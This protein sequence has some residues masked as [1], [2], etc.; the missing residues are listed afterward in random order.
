VRTAAAIL[1]GALACADEPVRL[2]NGLVV[3]LRPLE[4]ATGVTVMV[5]FDVGEDHD[6]VGRSGTAHL[7]EHLYVTAAA[8]SVKSRTVQEWLGAHSLGANA[9]TGGSYTLVSATCAPEAL[10]A[11][12]ADAAARMGDL[13]IEEADLERERPRVLEEVGNMF[14]NMP[15]LAA[16]NLAAHLARSPADGARK[17]GAPDQ[18]AKL[19][20]GDL[21][22]RW[23]RFYKPARARLIL[24]GKFDPAAALAKVRELFAPLPAGEARPAPAPRPE[25][26]GG[27]ERFE[28]GGGPG[29]HVA[30]A[31]EGPDPATP[32]FPAFLFLAARL[33]D[34]SSSLKAGPGRVQYQ[35]FDRPEVLTISMP[36]R[37]GK[38]ADEAVHELRDFVFGT[39]QEDIRKSERK[40]ALASFGLVLGLNEGMDPLYAQNTYGA[41]FAIGRQ[42]QLGFDPVAVRKALLEV[43][44]E[45]VARAA[46]FFANEKTGTAI[47]EPK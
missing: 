35:P 22:E 25:N 17:G 36:S 27:A 30:L 3:H 18:V 23:K 42:A 38:T 34:R 20:L 45:Q 26:A 13:R 16:P 7:L 21:R 9:Q 12:L 6:P 37:P 47:L 41:A 19:A 29:S 1:L 11:E 28:F 44:N 14:G 8:G 46:Q 4:G 15:A 32:E 24:A 10:E 39:I 5:L 40:K 31:W 2:E 33:I 43:T